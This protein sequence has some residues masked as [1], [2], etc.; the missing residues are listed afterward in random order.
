MSDFPLQM[1]DIQ[2]TLFEH[3]KVQDHVELDQ[4]DCEAILEAIEKFSEEVL[5]PLNGPADREGVKRHDDGSVTVPE[6]LK[7]AYQQFCEDGWLGMSAPESADGQDLPF[8]ILA[9]IDEVLISA[10]VSFHNYAGLS[11]ACANMLYKCGSEE[12][13]KRYATHLISGEWQGT[14]CLTEAGAGSDVGAS[15]TKAT[16]LGDGRYK[17]EGTKVFITS[18]EHNMTDNFV[19][20]V[21]ARIEGD[22]GGVKGLSIF[23]VPKYRFDDAGE[24]TVYNDVYCAGIEEKMGIHASVTTTMEF[25]RQGD[26]IGEMIGQAGQGIRI[27]FHIMNEERIAVG[28][29]GQALAAMAYGHALKYARE[30]VQGSDIQKGKSITTEKVSI[31]EHPDVRRML[32]TCKANTE[33]LRA[34]LFW[35]ALELQHAEKNPSLS[36]EERKAKS[37]LAAL[38]T[39]ICKAH[40]SELG[41][42]MCSL[43]L[44]V[45]GGYGYCQE[46]PAEQYVRDSRIACVYEGT[47]GIQAIDLLFRKVFGDEAA[48][49]RELDS[50]MA[51]TSAKLEADEELKSLKALFDEA[52]AEVLEVTAHLAKS[53]AGGLGAPALGAT[54]YLMLLGNLINAFLLLQQALVSRQWLSERGAPSK[55][56]EAFGEFVRKNPAASFY[57]SKIETAVF[58]VNQLLPENRWRALQITNESSNILA[59]YALVES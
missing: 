52:R 16:P 57:L 44:Q 50:L 40:G 38:L 27:M 23:I 42:Q 47:N 53:A 10:C 22:P 6:A 39:P 13:Q 12:Q 1:R 17:I 37:K 45:F 15:L 25:G 28:C 54:P 26:C 51:E 31:I 20:I 29:Q 18:G 46:F 58:H 3:L 35:T 56:D 34:M 24:A 2:F 55:T 48:T 59:S 4:D 49:L 14:M 30:R 9:A 11:R 36:K 33:A 32:M 19:H 5:A 41:F 43:A 21:L 8:P 7:V